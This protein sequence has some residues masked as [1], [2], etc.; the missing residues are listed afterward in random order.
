ME[1][2][3]CWPWKKGFSTRDNTRV[4]VTATSAKSE[5]TT[6]TIAR[7]TLV[8]DEVEENGSDKHGRRKTTKASNAAT[9]QLPGDPEKMPLESGGM[10]MG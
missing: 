9:N 8:I 7:L 2:K 4:G 10:E 3:K 6:G 1:R 5:K